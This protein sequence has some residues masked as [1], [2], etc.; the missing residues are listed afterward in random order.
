MTKSS[1]PKGWRLVKFGDVVDNMNET[2]RDPASMSLDRVVGLDHM[3]PES[4]P[5]KRWDNFSDLYEGT[6]FTRVFRSGQV[7]FGKRRAYQR[8]VSVP[9]FDGICSSDILVFQPKNEELLSVFLPFLV[10]S[11]GFFDHALGTSAGSLSPRT[12]W[13]ELAKYEF[14]L[15]SIAE[16]HR[17]VEAME[18]SDDCVESIRTARMKLGNLSKAW[19]ADAFS[20]VGMKSGMKSLDEVAEVVMGRQLSPSK[21]LGN[22]PLRY[23]RAAN[24]SPHGIDLTDVL[25]M[26]FTAQEENSFKS[27]IDDVLLVEGGNEKSVGCPALVTDGSE[28]LCIQNTLVRCRTKNKETLTPGFMYHLLKFNFDSGTFGKMC[29]GTTIMHLG[30]KRLAKLLVPVPALHEQRWIAK[31][32]NQF[33]KTKSLLDIQLSS[34]SVLRVALLESLMAGSYSNV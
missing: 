8:K 20:A 2:T 5:L 33:D 15:P 24:V 9:D 23:L 10:Q 14:A 19:A 3:D 25:E 4:L 1:L 18:V 30:Q 11:D 16:Q 34:V 17:I 6:S 32:L 12:K 29:A 21:R 13:Q 7:L 22:R 26:D 28:E 27:R 31:N